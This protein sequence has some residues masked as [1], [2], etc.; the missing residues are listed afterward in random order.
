MNIYKE[1]DT[2][3]KDYVGYSE[4]GLDYDDETKQTFANYECADL[5][6]YNSIV[7]ECSKHLDG[8]LK[9]KS[10]SRDAQICITNWE[11]VIQSY[12][13]YERTG[14]CS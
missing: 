9:L 2:I 6:L 13:E 11:E 12:S 5:Y 4:D 14:I 7:E 10:M 3:I 1:L 8:K